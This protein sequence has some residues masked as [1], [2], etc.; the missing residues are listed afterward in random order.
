LAFDILCTSF[1]LKK[2]IERVKRKK[3]RKKRTLSKFVLWFCTVKHSLDISEVFP[4]DFRDV[5]ASQQR[6]TGRRKSLD[7]GTSGP[8]NVRG[9]AG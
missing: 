6:F 3:E 2:K 4:P 5:V 7:S 8:C 1:R 9:V